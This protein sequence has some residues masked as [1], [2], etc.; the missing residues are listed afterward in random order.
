M[1]FLDAIGL[2]YFWEKIKSWVG[3][4]YLSLKGGNI[5]GS[6]Q[7]DNDEDPGLRII[8]GTSYSDQSLTISPTRIN[9]SYTD[10]DS[11][12]G[13]TVINDLD[14]QKGLITA[15][16]FT[17]IS[18]TSAQAL[19][20]DGSVKGIGS[21]NGIAG[22]DANGNV[23]L[24]NLGNLDTTVAEVVTELPTSNIKRHI[25]LVKDSDTTN[26]KYAEY[27]YTGDISAAYDST[28][29]E[30]LGDFRAT[31][32]L[33]DYAKKRDAVNLH[34]IILNKTAIGNTQQGL[35]EEQRIKF[36][37]IDDNDSLE[38]TFENA[39]TNMAGFMSVQDKNKLDRIAENAN[40]Y[41]LPLAANGTR[42]G[43]QVGY[44]AN[45]RNYPVQLSGEKA[46]VNVPWTDTNT[47][48]DLSPYAKTADVNAALAKKVDVVSGKGLS[49][50]DFTA[51]LK[52]KLNGIATGAT[53]DSAIT[54][55]EIDALFT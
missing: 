45:G 27:V 17:R 8:D 5:E 10:E 35:I 15:R 6:I 30:K 3:K 53:A 12:G 41:S 11:D 39:T 21:A 23:P 51:A 19:I 40:N 52:T 29:W 14:I 2:A 16:S 55:A 44:A 32:D 1:Q 7:I 48:Y 18:G 36:L 26:N 46:Y 33:A 37:N 38:I 43:I 24:A 4:N 22:L 50:E 54:T 25:Y 34:A 31:V 47:T 20:A 9:M 13:H 49:T 28:K 42:G